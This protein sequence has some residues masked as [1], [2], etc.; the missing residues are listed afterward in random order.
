MSNYNS[1][2][3]DKEMEDF[4][5]KGIE[6]LKKEVGKGNIKSNKKKL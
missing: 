1:H 6:D 3:S 5:C 4:F 2:L